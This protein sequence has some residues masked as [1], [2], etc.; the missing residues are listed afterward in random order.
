MADV[1][2]QEGELLLGTP[3]RQNQVGTKFTFCAYAHGDSRFCEP[4]P[5]LVYQRKTYVTVMWF[6]A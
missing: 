2:C 5:L 6:F 3:Q 4:L 1:G